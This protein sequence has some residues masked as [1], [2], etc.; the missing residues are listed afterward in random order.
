VPHRQVQAVRSSCEPL[1]APDSLR[2]RSRCL[3]DPRVSAPVLAAKLFLTTRCPRLAAPAHA[4]GSPDTL[5][6]ASGCSAFGESHKVADSERAERPADDGRDEMEGFVA[7]DESSLF[8][9][10]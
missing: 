8:V 1:T 10:S 7:F 4:T 6:A 2:S 5:S 3:C 9:L